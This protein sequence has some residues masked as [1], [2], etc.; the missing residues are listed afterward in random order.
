MGWAVLGKLMPANWPNMGLSIFLTILNLKYKI[1]VGLFHVKIAMVKNWDSWCQPVGLRL[2][3]E[4]FWF[5]FLTLGLSFNFQT[6]TPY[7]IV[8]I[9][10]QISAFLPS[11]S[12]Q[13]ALAREL[14]LRHIF[15]PK[16]KQKIFRPNWMQGGRVIRP[17]I[18]HRVTESQSHRVTT[19]ALPIWVGEIILSPFLINSPTHFARRGIIRELVFFSLYKGIQVSPFFFSFHHPCIFL[20]ICPLWWG[21]HW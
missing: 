18:A 12:A 20:S 5:G 2:S 9:A 16:W 13:L 19:F 15:L 17:L 11:A 7:Q 3:A 8:E 10:W 21:P 4:I 1:I 14:F 6:T